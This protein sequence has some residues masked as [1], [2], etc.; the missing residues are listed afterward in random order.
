[1]N[2]TNFIEKV[3]TKNISD[4]TLLEMAKVQK[5]MWAYGLGEYVRCNCCNEIYS[6]N[7]IFGH[8][9][10]EIK[11]QSVTKLEEIFLGDSVRCKECNSTNTE[12]MYDI[13]HNVQTFLE[14][15]KKESF[16]VLS[17]NVEG[18]II[19]FC[20]GFI[21]SFEEIYNNEL[22]SHYGNIDSIFLKKIIEEKLSISSLNNM[23]NFSSMGTYQK[24]ISYNFIYNLLRKFF[25]SINVD[26]LIPGITEL[27]KTNSLY[28]IYKMMGSI[29]L[30]LDRKYLNNL[31]DNYDSDIC[32]F[33]DP[34]NDFRTKYDIP[35]RELI[36]KHNI[37]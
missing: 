12:F 9:S 11:T 17:Y 5:D 24:Y 7:D 10:S 29:S 28:K 3:D 13:D 36:K 23:L 27:D 6:K 34:I 32:V 8:L 33:P 18:N 30:G 21:G 19:G 15:Y 35:F 26:G 20:D 16:L 31:S 4:S 25:R 1:M 14:R 22:L 37:K 2:N